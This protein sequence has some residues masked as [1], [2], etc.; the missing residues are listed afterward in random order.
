MKVSSDFGWIEFNKAF[1]SNFQNK[2]ETIC[3][4]QKFYVKL[5]ETQVYWLHASCTAK[6]YFNITFY[7][8][9]R[10]LEC[11]PCWCCVWIDCVLHVSQT[12]QGPNSYGSLGE[13]DRLFVLQWESST[14]RNKWVIVGSSEHKFLIKN[15]F[16]L[17][18]FLFVRFCDFTATMELYEGKTQANSTVWSSLYSPPIPLVERQTYIFPA[19]IASLRE[20]ITEKGITNKHVLSK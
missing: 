1:Q 4:P 15:V 12:C 6:N 19:N 10:H 11:V 20:T 16:W 14:T 5:S 17:I 13:L 9:Y 18:T 3:L 7:W 2:A 8:F